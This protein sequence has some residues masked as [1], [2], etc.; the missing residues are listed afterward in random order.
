[1]VA[2]DYE[3]VMARYEWGQ[4]MMHFHPPLGYDNYGRFVHPL[5][6]AFIDRVRLLVSQV[7]EDDLRSL[8]AFSRPEKLDVFVKNF[9]NEALLDVDG[10]LLKESGKRFGPGAV[11]ILLRDTQNTPFT[12]IAEPEKSSR[13]TGP[14]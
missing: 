6:S 12:A 13:H 2:G 14:P 1:K 9:F 7:D 8:S 5:E 11:L 10:K 3:R 4:M